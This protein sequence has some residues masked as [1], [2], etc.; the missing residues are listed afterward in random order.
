VLRE[1]DFLLR[2][3]ADRSTPF[4][5]VETNYLNTDMCKYKSLQK[6]KNRAQSADSSK[7]YSK[8]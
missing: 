1:I 7:A 4:T 5:F 8:D 3:F 2:K 6:D